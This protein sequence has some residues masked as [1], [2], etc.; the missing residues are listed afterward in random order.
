MI[1]VPKGITNKA[2]QS[3]D[4]EEDD[5]YLV[6]YFKNMDK[7]KFNIGD[8]LIA[9]HQN[10]DGNMVTEMDEELSI[11]QKYVCVANKDGHSV[12]ASLFS[13]GTIDT[14][15][16]GYQYLP[17]SINKYYY[18][19]ICPDYANHM[20][21][22]PDE[23][24]DPGERGKEL[25]KQFKEITKYNT[26]KLQELGRSIEENNKYAE[27]INV[28]DK[29][30][31]GS[32]SSPQ[33]RDLAD[34]MYFVKYCEHEVLSKRKVKLSKKQKKF[35]GKNRGQA[36][37]YYTLRIRNTDPELGFNDHF[38]TL[39]VGRKTVSIGQLKKYEQKI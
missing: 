35:Y 26:D 10:D 29:I 7:F 27:T 9:K 2:L 18:F 11:P 31:I 19:E 34:M 37:H 8:I 15:E 3:V 17:L 20:L 1:K 24:Y 39:G 12:I 14:D 22:T 23:K 13:D 36:T 21:L 33:S 32:L 28:G 6:F 16:Y 5:G 25:H 30:H 38:N 4:N